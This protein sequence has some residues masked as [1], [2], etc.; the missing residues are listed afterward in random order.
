MV[1]DFSASHLQ[2]V[3]NAIAEWRW[4]Q[5]AIAKQK[6]R[7]VAESNQSQPSEEF[8]LAWKSGWLDCIEFLGRNDVANITKLHHRL[9]K[10][11]PPMRSVQSSCMES[12]QGEAE[13]KQNH[14]RVLDKDFLLYQITNRIRHSLDEAQVCQAI[15]QQLCR[16]LEGD[17]AG[18][19]LYNLENQTLS[20]AAAHHQS[21]LV[22]GQS[23]VMIQGLTLRLGTPNERNIRWNFPHSPWMIS[24]LTKAQLPEQELSVLQASGINSALMIPIVFQSQLLGLAYVALNISC[25]FWTSEE[26]NLAGM[27][28][29]QAAIAITHARLFSAQMQRGKREQVLHRLQERIRTS[30]DIETTINL[31]LEELLQLTGADAIV[32]SLPLEYD[33]KTLRIAHRKIREAEVGKSDK[34]SPINPPIPVSVYSHLDIGTEINL[35]NFG[36]A[37]L[38]KFLNPGVSA[39][40][41]TQTSE[42]PNQART[43]FWQQQIGAFLHSPIIYQ[44]RLSG[45]LSAIKQQPYEWKT[46]EITAIKAVASCLAIAIAHQQFYAQLQQQADLAASQAERL[47]QSDLFLRTIIDSTPD[48]IFVKDRQLRYVLVN[49]GFAKTM[50]RQPED[51]LGLT[52]YDFFPTELI[53]GCAE[54]NIRGK[55]ADD[56]QVINT[57]KMVRNENDWVQDPQENFFCFNSLKMPLRDDRNNVIGVIGIARDETERYRLQ[58]EREHLYAET[59]RRAERETLL[60]QLTASLHS[61]LDLNQLTKQICQGL[62]EALEVD[63]VS[64]WLFNEDFSQLICQHRTFQE[65]DIPPINAIAVAELP[66]YFKSISSQQPLVASTACSDDRLQ[67]LWLDFLENFYVQSRLDL[68]IVHPSGEQASQE[69]PKEQLPLSNLIGVLCLEHCSPRYWQAEEVALVKAVSD[70]LAIAITQAQLYKR[71]QE[72]ALEAQA[73]AKRLTHTLEELYKT[74]SQLI[75]SEKMSSLGQMVAGVAHEINNPINFIYGNIPHITN[76]T[77]DILKLID[78][79]RTNYQDC[80]TEITEFEEEIDLDFLKS[81]FIKILNSMNTGAQRVREIVLTLR[82]FSRIEE[83]EVKV[84]DLHEGI[85][86]TLILLNHRLKRDIEVVRDYGNLPKVECYP[87]Q[88]NQVFM[89]ILSNAIDSLESRCANDALKSSD[90]KHDENEPMR[91]AIRTEMANNDYAIV[92]IADNGTGMTDEV[93]HKLFDPF[94]TTKPVGKGT[95][96]GLSISYKII[97]EKHRG[98][99]W[100]IS[101]PG[102]GTEFWIKIPICQIKQ[103]VTTIDLA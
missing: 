9:Y 83:A 60:N 33:P 1:I 71:T 42:L 68:P 12:S 13:V 80:P 44:E 90:R 63:R 99:L 45:H 46:H 73:Q 76:Y 78:L 17:C 16:A 67:E 50:G 24:D 28:A 38:Q 72:Q 85:D 3:A 56:L 8:H 2:S 49:Q 95:G 57:G 93:H 30:L 84:V 97:V 87:G 88:L 103:P 27:V 5:I 91:I 36:S 43:Y 64:I 51:F 14:S 48:W 86:S 41:N 79:Y 100:C 54:L 37:Y 22:Q 55:R 23:T 34:N 75:Q 31:A 74:Q 59:H 66:A 35:E 15:A 40:G 7:S 92:R 77:E 10:H 26:I 6:S 4:R 62:S 19:I 21:E 53:E 18:L 89:N 20:V 81:D 96:L 98:W 69:T 32:F 70:Q 25:R 39:I 102:K 82:N 65:S 29:E 11:W 101:E 52:D 58:Q 94:F 47:Q 61:N